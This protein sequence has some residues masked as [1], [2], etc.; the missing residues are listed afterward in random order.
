MEGFGNIGRTVVDDAGA[1]ASDGL[2]RAIAMLLGVY[3]CHHLPNEFGWVN[4]KVEEGALRGCGADQ[5][6]RRKLVVWLE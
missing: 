3:L 5:G 4:G 2:M 6:V 1:S